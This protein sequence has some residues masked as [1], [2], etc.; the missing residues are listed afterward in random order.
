MTIATKLLILFIWTGVAALLYL[1]NR[2][3]RF[4]P[5]DHGRAFLL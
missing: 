1:L 5:D 3:G 4:F 2:I